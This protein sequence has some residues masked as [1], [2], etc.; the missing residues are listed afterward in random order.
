MNMF[1][2]TH[3]FVTDHF[4]RHYTVNNNFLLINA[5]TQIQHR[6]LENTGYES[7]FIACHQNTLSQIRKQHKTLKFTAAVEIILLIRKSSFFALVLKTNGI[8]VCKNIWNS[9]I[10]VK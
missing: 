7:D 6:T 1:D 10:D 9:M 4:I 8:L 2:R 5:K 3:A